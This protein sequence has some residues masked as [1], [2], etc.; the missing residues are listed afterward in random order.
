MLVRM[1]SR[2]LYNERTSEIN[3]YFEFL[4]DVLDKRPKL[5]FSD[6]ERAFDRDLIH[7]LKANAY[8]VVYNLIESTVCN[9]IEDI[10]NTLKAET[11]LCA[12]K[13]NI[14]LAK[15]AFKK[16]NDKTIS[17]ANL[18]NTSVGVF[19][20]KEWLNDHDQVIRSNKNPLF[21]GNV[22]ARKIREV[23]ELYGFSYQTDQAVTRNGSSLNSIKNTRN[24][25]AH[26]TDSFKDR[27][28]QTSV[29]ELKAMKDE[30]IA[31]LDQMLTNIESYLNTQSYFR[32]EYRAGA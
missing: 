8:L 27:G 18:S 25:L 11:G 14:E 1:D 10:H 3:L 20:V 13:L 12:D 19:I 15:R 23:A 2:H 9:A 5:K 22:D 29:D 28:Q 4:F 32:V 26:G 7:I 24:N 16:V 6:E 30:V 17:Q 21:S 31:Y